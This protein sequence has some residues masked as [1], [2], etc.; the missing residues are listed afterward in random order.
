MRSEPMT[1]G[2][3]ERLGPMARE[4]ML[5]AGL[6]FEAVQRIA[7]TIGPGSFTGLRVGLAFAKGL[8]LAL[9]IPLAGIGTLEA[10]AGVSAGRCAAVIDG[11]RGRVYV[12]AFLGEAVNQPASLEIGEAGAALRVLLGDEARLT[13][14]GGPL[15]APLLPRWEVESRAAPDPLVLARLAAN[16][17]LQTAQPLYLRPP[18]ATPKALRQPQ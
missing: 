6:E 14:P 13:G 17:P 15:L 7:V 3:Q 1:R 8:G 2:H 16:R 12:Q 9:G 18:D 10:L 5:A 4:V 11:G